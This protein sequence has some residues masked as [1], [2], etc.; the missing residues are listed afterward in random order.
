[1]DLIGV[2]PA[3]LASQRLPE[4]ALAEIG[5]EPMILAVWRRARRVLDRVILAVDGPALAAVGEAAGAEVVITD[6][7]LPSGSDR[8]A[9]AL[10][11]LRLRPD[12]VINIQGDQPFLAEAHLRALCGPLGGA[13]VTTLAAPLADP[14]DPARVKVVCDPRGRALY[15]SRA[16]IPHG[17]PYRQHVGLYRFSPEA[18]AR[19]VAAPPSPLERVERLEQLRLMEIGV[20]IDVIDVDEPAFS[21]DT[22]EDLAEARRRVAVSSARRPAP[23]RP[24][25]P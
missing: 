17:G 20:P 23:G 10:D 12:A 2:I 1:V 4:K 18:L 5:G 22:A 19:F 8:V 13:P 15:F 14:A 21:V 25:G 3:R 11:A 7:A 6:P 24:G 16:A 9:A